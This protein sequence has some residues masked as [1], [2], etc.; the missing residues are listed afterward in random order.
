MTAQLVVY[1]RVFAQNVTLFINVDRLTMSKSFRFISVSFLPPLVLLGDAVCTVNGQT[2]GSGSVTALLYQS[3][4]LVLE[5][6]SYIGNV[7]TIACAIEVQLAYSPASKNVNITTDVDSP[8][9]GPSSTT[10]DACVALCPALSG[11]SANIQ[12]DVPAAGQSLSSIALS[13]SGFTSAKSIRLIFITDL[14]PFS[15]PSNVTCATN[16][17]VFA[18]VPSAPLL[19]N[20]VL[21]FASSAVLPDSS[22]MNCTVSLLFDVAGII[23]M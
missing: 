14:P 21:Q 9:A 15:A 12:V 6:S 19:G 8:S 3:D 7:P 1:P 5:F 20:L 22:G 16:G 11:I 10:V 18:A 13:I 2:L 17:T 23:L 4:H